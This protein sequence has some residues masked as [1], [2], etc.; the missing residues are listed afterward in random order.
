MR[1]LQSGATDGKR[2]FL[3]KG[4]KLPKP[5]RMGKNYGLQDLQS[6]GGFSLW[7]CRLRQP[8]VASIASTIAQTIQRLNDNITHSK[9][10]APGSQPR[11][12]ENG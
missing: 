1:G 9:S 6:C 2:E 12:N 7:H 11:W 5:F 3:R 8:T 4:L 10:D